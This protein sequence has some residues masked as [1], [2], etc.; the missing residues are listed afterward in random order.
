MYLPI[1]ENQTVEFDQEELSKIESI[2]Q[3]L[4]L[5]KNLFVSGLA[6]LTKVEEM[7]LSNEDKDKVMAIKENFSN[8]LKRG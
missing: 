3:W 7:S 4:T 1:D 2:E 8:I 6:V 5:V